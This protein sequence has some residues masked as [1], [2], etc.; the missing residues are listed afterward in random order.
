MSLPELAQLD[1]QRSWK[2]HPAF[3][4]SFATDVNQ[5]AG[6]VDI[7]HAEQA[8]LL[9]PEPAGV[10]GGEVH[11]EGRSLDAGQEAADFVAAENGGEAF[12]FAGP[13]HGEERPASLQGAL[14]E[15]LQC[16][17][18]GRGQGPGDVPY[19]GEVEEVL[20]DL[21]LAEQIGRLVVVLG[22]LA[23]DVD[24]DGLGAGRQPAELHVLEEALP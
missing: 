23:D 12:D 5:A 4:G 14:E 21:V 15:E 13:G 20:T 18:G 22:D 10:D 24:V 17:E 2:G 3:L 19:L 6:A 9:A 11:V 16:A 7:L 8:G 1:E